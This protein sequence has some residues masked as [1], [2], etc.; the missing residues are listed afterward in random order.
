MGRRKKSKNRNQAP[1]LTSLIMRLFSKNPQVSLNY[2]QVSTRL[3]LEGPADRKRVQKALHKLKSSGDLVEIQPGKYRLKSIKTYIT[4]RVDMTRSG[5][6]YIISEET[7][8]DVFINHGNM[9][10]ALHNDIVKVFIFARKRDGKLYGEIVEVLERAHDVFVGQLQ[11]QN[12]TAFLIPDNHRIAV[13]FFVP[14]NSLKGAEH[15][16]KV[17]VK[18]KEWPKGAK[19]PVGEVDRIL[20]KPGEN[21]TEIHAILAEYN[22]PY[23]FPDEVEADAENLAVEIPDS[24]IKK[25]KDLRDVLTF[26]IDPHDA[27]DFDDALSFEK[28]ENGNIRLGVHIADVSHYV[29]PGTLLDREAYDRGTSVY[30]VD[31]VVPMLPEILSNNVCSLRPNE[32]KLTFSSI[33]ELDESGKVHSVW[34]GRTVTR[35]D[36]RFAYEEAQEVIEKGEGPLDHAILPLHRIA[37]NLRKKR[38]KNGALIFD[39][40]EVKFNL[41]DEGTPNSVYFKRSKE[42]NQLIEEFMLLANRKVAEFVGKRKGESKPKTFVY[43]IHDSPDPEKLQTLGEF[44][45][46][47]GYQV[48]LGSHKVIS[49]S[50]NKMLKEVVGKKEENMIEQLTLRSMSKAV[51]STENIGHYG[52]AFDHYSHFTSPIRRYPDVMVHRLLQTYLDQGK[53]ADADDYEQKCKHCSDRERVA[54]EAERDSIKFM[55][56]KYMQGQED[57]EWKGYI[58]GVT[59]YGIFV[60]IEANH[61]EGLVRTH[62][63]GDDFFVY[64]DGNFRYRGTQKGTVYQLGDEILVKVKHADLMKKQLD[65]KVVTAES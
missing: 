60:T 61:C 62:D 3:S 56:V 5:T 59:E 2:K 39:K 29:K 18:L 26:T 16:D 46:Q 23:D 10:Q 1:G 35:S 8:K 9:N 53:S 64:E 42:A 34:F 57:K 51:Y 21:D 45:Q 65:L 14:M 30:L 20:G 24:E 17:T 38:V 52:L 12:N 58:S 7:E 40:E 11:I 19:N 48:N 15:G 55:Q 13:D 36:Q 22:L 33:F 25:R 6:A 43:R 27:K 37:Q 28:L 41:D 63:M 44:V 47:F 4:G 49:S 31:R 32:D 50:L 54:T